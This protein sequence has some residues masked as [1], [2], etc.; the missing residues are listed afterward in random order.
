MSIRKALTYISAHLD[1]WKAAAAKWTADKH[2]RYPKGH[3]KAGKFMPKNKGAEGSSE[4]SSGKSASPSKAKAKV[5]PV[6]VKTKYGTFDAHRTKLDNEADVVAFQG[7][8]KKW[9]VVDLKTKKPL[10]LKGQ[11]PK[12]AQEALKSANSQ[13]AKRGEGTESTS[14]PER[15]TARKQPTPRKDEGKAK[16]SPT[17]DSSKKTSEA[18]REPFP[19]GSKLFAKQEHA[20]M[21]QEALDSYRAQSK[22]QLLKTWETSEKVEVV[23]QATE[24]WT[25]STRWGLP[26]SLK[27]KAR[28]LEGLEP[29]LRIKPGDKT[30]YKEAAK[31]ISDAEYLHARAMSQAYLEKTVP[32]TVTLYRGVDGTTGPQMRQT[33]IKE[34]AQSDLIQIREEPAVGFTD[35]KSIADSFGKDAGGITIKE[36]VARSDILFPPKFLGQDFAAEREYIVR[37]REH[38]WQMGEDLL[39]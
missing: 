13:V 30:N 32:E 4:S 11:E 28:S 33:I 25:A 5:E 7:P 14:K 36:A 3:P 12:S 20:K 37:N 29:E 27:E 9:Y 31:E 35:K 1:S 22:K 2:P 21:F 17:T 39:K 38:R 8:N 6:K 16:E 34:N 19:D 26:M 24:D 18:S 15:T 10:D 23:R